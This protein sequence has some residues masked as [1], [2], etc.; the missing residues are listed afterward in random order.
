MKNQRVN[1]CHGERAYVYVC[2]DKRMS[3]RIEFCTNWLTSFGARKLAA[4]LLE[5]ADE[6]DEKG[7][8]YTYV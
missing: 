8:V 3:L 2:S 1:L 4:T 5:A 7:Q 6:L